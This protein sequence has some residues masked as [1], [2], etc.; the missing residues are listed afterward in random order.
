MAEKLKLPEDSIY[1]ISLNSYRALEIVR[2]VC[3][4]MRKSQ[5][6]VGDHDFPEILYAAQDLLMK[7]KKVFN[8]QELVIISIKK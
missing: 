6:Y 4:V 1:E 7:N 5:D 8:E 3:D 2:I